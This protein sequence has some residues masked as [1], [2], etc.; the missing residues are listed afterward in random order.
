[1]HKDI[2]VYNLDMPKDSVQDD[3]ILDDD[4]S[5][6]EA[7]PEEMETDIDGLS[8]DVKEALGLDE[9]G[10][11]KPKA[12]GKLPIKEI[13]PVMDWLPADDAK[14]LERIDSLF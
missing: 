13:T 2:I 3:Y 14:A 11:E 9:D 4:D 10:E 5:A 7:E 12:R 1:L 8:Y 6:E